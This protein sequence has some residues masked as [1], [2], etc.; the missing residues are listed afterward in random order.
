VPKAAS[1]L[2]AAVDRKPPHTLIWNR[3]SVPYL[4]GEAVDL[5]SMRRLDLKSEID[6]WTPIIKKAGVSVD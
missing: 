4:P 6:R 2:T 5:G 3:R 1:G